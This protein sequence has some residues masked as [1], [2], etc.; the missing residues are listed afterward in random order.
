RINLDSQTLLGEVVHD[1]QAA[2]S[3]TISQSIRYKVHR[4]ALIAHG[5][6]NLQLPLHARNPLPLAAPDAQACLPIHPKQLLSIDAAILPAASIHADA[7]SHIGVLWPPV[8]KD[9]DA[10]PHRQDDGIR[11]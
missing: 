8:R 5:R 11:S 9:A 6:S 7:D 4:P 2:Q 1:V 3:A 10:T